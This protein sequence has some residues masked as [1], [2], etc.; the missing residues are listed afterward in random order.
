MLQSKRKGI[1]CQHALDKFTRLG[2][3]EEMTIEDDWVID[4]YEKDLVKKLMNCYKE[5]GEFIQPW[6]E[7]GMLA[8][9]KVDLFNISRVMYYPPKENHTRM[10]NGKVHVASEVCLEGTWK[11][12]LEGGTYTSIIEEFVDELF[13]SRFVNEC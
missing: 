12:L 11:A 3:K 13:G 9:V 5:D 4:M 7:D 8:K 1:C 2:V 10:K 6:T